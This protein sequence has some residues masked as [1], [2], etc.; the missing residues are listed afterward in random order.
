MPNQ[1]RFIE[2]KDMEYSSVQKA[3]G[4]LLSFVPDNR[5]MGTSQLSETLGLNKST[6][7]RLTHV[8]VHYGLIQQDEK[9]KKYS[10]G[11][12]AALLG[13]AVEASQI[14][15]LAQFARPYIDALSA[16]VGESVCLEMLLSRRTKLIYSVI[17]PP[18]V[19]VTFQDRLPMHAA[20]GGKAIL[21]YTDSEEV[22]NMLNGELKRMT[23]NTIC[24]IEQFKA[25]L[26]EIRKQGI[27]YD[28]GEA[29]TD[30][31]AVS[32]PVRNHLKKPVAAVSICVPATRVNKIMNNKTVNELRKTARRISEH[33]FFVD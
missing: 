21:A 31:H 23:E 18:P 32:A 5:P 22:E 25:H 16:A 2:N 12:T 27:A 9:S 28:H 1:N 10:L 6:V 19:S 17:G 7:S 14:D 24:D 4:I 13:K 26:A 8:L 20:A 33:L 29:N 11:R 3:I 15:R 30:V